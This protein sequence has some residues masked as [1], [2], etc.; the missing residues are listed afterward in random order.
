MHR[1]R[2]ARAGDRGPWLSDLQAA[3][4]AVG[5]LPNDAQG[6]WPPR[7]PDDEAA[8]PC[9]GSPSSR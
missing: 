5:Q 9:A 4:R 2:R 1:R 6:G 3:V 8:W 7:P